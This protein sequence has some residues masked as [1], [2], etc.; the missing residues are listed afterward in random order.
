MTKYGR[1]SKPFF[2][3]IGW[4]GRGPDVIDGHGVGPHSRGPTPAL[5]EASAITSRSMDD[6]IPF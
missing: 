6:E 2:K 3:V 5:V 1:K 4:R